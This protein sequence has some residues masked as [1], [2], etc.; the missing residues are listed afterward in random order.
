MPLPELVPFADFKQMATTHE[1][2]EHLVPGIVDNL[3]RHIEPGPDGSPH[4]RVQNR[5]PSKLS[6]AARAKAEQLAQRHAQDSMMGGSKAVTGE[7]Y[8]GTLV[9]LGDLLR[10]YGPAAVNIMFP[11]ILNKA[12]G[13]QSYMKQFGTDKQGR[14]LVPAPG[15]EQ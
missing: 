2:A 9:P 4:V 12:D 15:G 8:Q 14:L 1:D 6:E 13:Y 10:E 3:H 11:G 7:S 5:E